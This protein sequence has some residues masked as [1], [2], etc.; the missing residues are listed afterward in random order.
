MKLRKKIVLTAK[1]IEKNIKE[2]DN[3][4]LFYIFTAI[5]TVGSIWLFLES[6]YFKFLPISDLFIFFF[7]LSMVFFIP[8]AIGES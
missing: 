4:N 3:T 5:M 7:I 6:V 1:L 8:W 2:S